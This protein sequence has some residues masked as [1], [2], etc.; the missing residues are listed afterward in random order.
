MAIVVA[1]AVSSAAA[2]SGRTTIQLKG[3]IGLNDSLVVS[4][5]TMGQGKEIFDRFGHIAIRVRNPGTGLDS[6]WN[7]GM[8]DFDSPNFLSRWLTGKTQYWAA[9]FPSP[10]FIDYYKR[11]GR[12][13]WEQVI[14]LDRQEADSLLTLLRWQVRNENKFYRYDYYLDNC[15]TRV[16]D[17]LDAV[18]GGALKRKLT[19]PG[20][21]VTWRG[22]TLRLSAT[23]PAIA[24]G[25]TFA[26]G[27]R[28]DEKISEWDELFIP[29][30]L[31]DR[32]RDLKVTRASG[33][34]PLVSSEQVLVAPGQ[35]VEAASPPSFVAAGGILGVA[36]AALIYA[37]GRIGSRSA[38]ARIALGAFASLWHFVAGFAGTLV[39]WAGLFTRHAFMAGNTSVLLGTPVSLA[40]AVMIPLALSARAT[41]PLR[42]ATMA[43]STFVALEALA[44]VV[45]YL[46]ASHASRDLSP[47]ML[48][49]QVHA[50]LA[51]VLYRLLREKPATA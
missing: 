43:L 25:M 44:C 40:L 8:Y 23:F 24:F 6:A 14:D 47:W 9:A 13:V 26:L 21:G 22:E 48:A 35:F 39:L 5:L 11:E 37:L 32:I 50:A 12:A 36:L 15:S 45:V 17:A 51:V 2:Q 28:A 4:I 31:R 30:R 18:L 46:V 29:M 1:A 49:I 34:R 3:S 7:W 41:L 33:E 16:R 19:G 20:D 10:L 42:K 38:G 27:P